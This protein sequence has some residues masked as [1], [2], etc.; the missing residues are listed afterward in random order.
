MRRAAPD[1]PVRWQSPGRGLPVFLMFA[2][3]LATKIQ[4]LAR[5]HKA[6][7]EAQEELLRLREE[8]REEQ[9]LKESSAATKI[10]SLARSHKARKEALRLKNLTECHEAPPDASGKSRK[11]NPPRSGLGSADSPVPQLAAITL[12]GQR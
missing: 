1:A 7:K 9:Q 4:S 2:L 10:Q 5:S 6:R 11:P 12:A 3:A 8:Q